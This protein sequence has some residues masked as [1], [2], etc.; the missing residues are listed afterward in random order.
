M[1]DAI[2]RNLRV[3]AL[4]VV[5]V[6]LLALVVFTIGNRRQ[7]FTRHTRYVT[8][9]RNVTGL[10][11]GAPVKLSG[12]D[13][14]FI[15]R[16]VLP[17]DPKQQRITVRFTLDAEYTERVREDTRVLIRSIGLLGDKYLE[18]QGGTADSPRVLEGGEVAGIDRAELDAFMSSSE[19][20]IANLVA[21]SSSLKVVLRRIEGGEGL[22]GE[23][24]IRPASSESLSD[25]LITTVTELRTILRRVEAGE[26]MIG[27]LLRED[28]ASS[29]LLTEVEHTVRS[30]RDVT[31]TLAVDLG[32]D[33]TAYAALLRDPRG[34]ELML[35]SVAALRDAGQALAA[36]VEEL[37]SGEG[38][39]PRLMADK[40]YADDF[41]DDLGELM[42]NLRSISS[43]ID[44]GEGTAGAF[45]NDPQMYQDL[46]DVV[47]GVKESKV[48]SWFIRNR[49][50]KGEKVRTEDEA[51]RGDADEAASDSS[52][53]A[54]PAG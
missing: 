12:V 3:G 5:A 33:D 51:A 13:V 54:S 29:G 23:L 18:V 42:E 30:V 46:E 35:E 4:T 34:G 38:T 40:E 20:L 8:T 27:R 19:D 49:R 39:L 43:T 22:L 11:P 28:D 21:I 9:F 10:Q 31:T 36:A 52:T 50:H 26:G 32:R 15:E 41:L 48:V 2:K 7:L 6:A 17:I 25:V 14:G 45:I 53:V 24:T 47:R 1:R 37:A 16:I 44:S